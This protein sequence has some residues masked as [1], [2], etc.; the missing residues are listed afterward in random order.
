M[1][2]FYNDLCHITGSDNALKDEEMKYHTTFCVGGK[3]DFYVKP[4]SIEE[5]QQIIK[6]C[7][8]YGKEYF[9]IGKGSNL[10]VSDSGYRGVIIQ[11]Y[12]N[13]CDVHIKDN[14][15]VSRAGA[16]MSK[17]AQSACE[18]SLAGLEFSYGIPGTVGGAVTMN[19]GAYGGEMKHIVEYVTVMDPKGN[20]K[21]LNNEELRFGYRK[22][23]I[24]QSSFII[25]EVGL[26]LTKGNR[27]EIRDKM[28]DY[29]ARRKEKQPLEFP[30]A[31]SAFKRPEGM[32]AGKLIMDAGLKGYAVGGARVSDKHCGFIINYD[33]ATAAHV[34][35]LVKDIQA[36][37]KEKFGVNLEMEIQ[38]LG[39][40]SETE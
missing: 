19:A 35:L 40:F 1:N 32:Y 24:K 8:E 10:L 27:Q 30:S 34:M 26:K 6:L 5:I 3:A 33:N 7:K 37:V 12:H 38:K 22:S 25:L 2:C 36:K 17:L 16:L 29:A 28:E 11:M 9:I 21:N 31:G 20:V 15:L 18:G 14:I 13:F 4:H 23:I 39:E